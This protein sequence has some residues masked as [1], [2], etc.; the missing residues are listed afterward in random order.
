MVLALADV[1]STPD[2][3]SPRKFVLF[4][5][6]DRKVR[7]LTQVVAELQ[8]SNVVPVSGDFT[9]PMAQANGGVAA[10]DTLPERFSVICARA[11]AP[12]AELWDNLQHLLPENGE[13]LVACG[14]QTREQLPPGVQ[15]EWF[16]NQASEGR[17]VVRLGR[18]K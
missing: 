1:A 4:D 18:Q 8:L 15:V 17:G 12:P 7:F 13:L 6:S 14:P 9:K 11:V 16:E 3:T 10:L 2:S 5:R